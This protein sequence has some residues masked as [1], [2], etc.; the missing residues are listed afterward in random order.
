MISSGDHVPASCALGGGQ[1]RP[2]DATTASTVTTSATAP[3][4]LG[5]P[6]MHHPQQQ[7]QEQQHLLRKHHGAPAGKAHLA[8]QQQQQGGPAVAAAA[9][10]E[11]L[12]DSWCSHETTLSSLAWSPLAGGSVCNP[13]H[14][15]GSGFATTPPAVGGLM[16]HLRQHLHAPSPSF[17]RAATSGSELSLPGTESHEGAAMAERS[18]LYAHTLAPAAAAAHQGRPRGPLLRAR[19][20]PAEPPLVAERP[21]SEG[22]GLAPPLLRPPSRGAHKDAVSGH[23]LHLREDAA[24]DAT[25]RRSVDFYGAGARKV[26]NM[27][28]WPTVDAHDSSSLAGSA[29]TVIGSACGTPTSGGDGGGDG[30]TILAGWPAARSPAPPVRFTSRAWSG[31]SVATAATAPAAA[32]PKAGASLA[33]NPGNGS[34]NVDGAAAV[35]PWCRSAPS[36]PLGSPP[37]TLA[38]VGS[39]V[40]LADMDSQ[41]CSSASNNAAA[42][43]TALL[44]SSV[45]PGRGSSRKARHQATVRRS[46]TFGSTLENGGGDG[47]RSAESTEAT[48]APRASAAPAGAERSAAADSGGAPAVERG[49]ASEGG[50]AA[51]QRTQRPPA[52]GEGGRLGSSS[53]S[54]AVPALRA[55]AQLMELWATLR[56]MRGDGG[57][58]RG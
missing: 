41:C 46:V 42:T 51:Q 8:D 43:A 47:A 26:F 39:R 55:E 58:S 52:A 54:A 16:A 23:A 25:R 5:L 28:I 36:W 14:G 37:Q 38:T 30:T 40:G 15:S 21:P 48:L 35:Q 31:P 13:H 9:A 34:A 45:P 2:S 11:A 22:E 12:V 4:V 3:S 6:H 33:S 1:Q 18:S 50:W 17:P 44:M 56:G 24:S 29:P 19:A 53:F 32:T 49:G 7:Q 20:A 10:G 57:G 27:A